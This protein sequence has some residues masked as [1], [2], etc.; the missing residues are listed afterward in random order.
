MCLH[1]KAN[2]TG[3]ERLGKEEKEKK[4][5]NTVQAVFKW[6]YIA[7]M[8]AWATKVHLEQNLQSHWKSLRI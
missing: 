8:L 7:G 3:E 5:S 1:N 2:I 6:F 4:K